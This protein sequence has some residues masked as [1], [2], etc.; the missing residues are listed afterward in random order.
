[1][2]AF[3]KEELEDLWHCVDLYKDGS[4]L[5]KHPYQSL[6]NKIQSAINNHCDHKDNNNCFERVAICSKCDNPK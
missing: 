2:N 5:K 4:R 3:T 1:M 6:L